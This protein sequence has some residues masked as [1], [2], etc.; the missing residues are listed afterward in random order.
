[1][2]GAPL[3]KWP[4]DSSCS[5]NVGLQLTMGVHLSRQIPSWDS[6][7]RNLFSRSTK[8]GQ[9][10][11]YGQLWVP[12]DEICESFAILEDKERSRFQKLGKINQ[13]AIE[14]IAVSLMFQFRL[15]RDGNAT[16]YS[17]TFTRNSQERQDW[18]CQK[19][20]YIAS[21]PAD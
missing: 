18:V 21:L 16:N 3:S 6:H 15:W 11:T 20:S 8:G 7:Q 9:Q 17:E 10:K 19:K 1:M 4:R 12:D 14:S 13:I 5:N 2:R